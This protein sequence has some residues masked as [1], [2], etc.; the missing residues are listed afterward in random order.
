VSWNRLA[1]RRPKLGHIGHEGL[2]KPPLSFRYYRFMLLLKI[3]FPW[4]RCRRNALPYRIAS[5][6]QGHAAFTT[7]R[8]ASPLNGIALRKRLAGNNH[9]CIASSCIS[10][11]GLHANDYVVLHD[12]A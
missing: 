5:P 11:R 8:D 9:A 6:V 4:L 12:N 7:I 2:G 3:R 10:G 1:K